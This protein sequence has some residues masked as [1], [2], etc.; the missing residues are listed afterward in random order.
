MLDAESFAI[1]V[2]AQEADDRII[3]DPESGHVIY[4]SDGSGGGGASG[5]FMI[6]TA[7]TEIDHTDFIGYG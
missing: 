5:L 4:D 1:G 2:A 6:V 3:Y 7:G